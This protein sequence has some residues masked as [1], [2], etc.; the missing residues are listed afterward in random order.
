MTLLKVSV[1]SRLKKN[2]QLHIIIIQLM[3]SVR[4]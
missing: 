1:I 3:D 4:V 2:H